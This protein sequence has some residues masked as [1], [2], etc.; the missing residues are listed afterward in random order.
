MTL[1]GFRAPGDPG[2][3]RN[4]VSDGIRLPHASG[5][6]PFGQDDD[7]VWIGF[8]PEHP[9]T[10]HADRVVS[11]LPS[12]SFLFQV[13]LWRFLEL[14]A[15][16][17]LTAPFGIWRVSGEPATQV[18]PQLGAGLLFYVFRHRRVH[19]ALRAGFDTL[20]LIKHPRQA[21][22]SDE[23]AR[24]EHGTRRGDDGEPEVDEKLHGNL[25]SSARR[26]LAGADRRRGGSPPSGP[27]SG[28]AEAVRP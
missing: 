23:E 26:S 2:G 21:R 13:H 15:S 22:L 19:V 9:V 6:L 20:P 27:T 24:E 8:K 3:D 1:L 28:G 7:Q 14:D 25:L 12:V 18:S 11:L 4:G 10:P 5:F 16:V 17:G